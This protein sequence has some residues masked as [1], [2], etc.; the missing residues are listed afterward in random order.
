MRSPEVPNE[1]QGLFLGVCSV[2]L[3]DSFVTRT[4]HPVLSLPIQLFGVE[5][6]CR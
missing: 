2:V 1:S 6:K 4:L 3:T 5:T